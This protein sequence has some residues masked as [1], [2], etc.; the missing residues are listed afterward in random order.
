[1][2]AVTRFQF[3]V[4]ERILLHL[5]DY[6]KYADQYEVP[7]SVAQKGIGDAV[8]IVWNNVPR[9]MKK[10]M[11]KGAVVERLAH[12]KG[13][14]RKK[15][16]YFLTTVGFSQAKKLKDTIEQSKM[17]FK[18]ASGQTKTIALGEI[19]AL[20]NSKPPI[21]DIIRHLDATGVFDSTVAMKKG[22]PKGDELVDFS[23]KAP[24]MRYFFGRK[25]ELEEIKDL[26]DSHK[27]VIVH[28]IAGIGKTT[29]ALKIL[30]E[31]KQSMNTFWYRFHEWDTLRNLLTQLS[32]FLQACGRKAL[33]AYLDGTKTMDIN[34]AV[35]AFQKDIEDLMV[36][37][38]FDD[39]QKAVDEASQFFAAVTEVMEAIK[40]AKILIM[41][42]R[43]PG[44]YDRRAV[45][46]KEV[47]AEMKL[48]GLDK[49]SSRELLKM[50]NIVD[51]DI[52]DEIYRL[53][54]GHPLSL[55]L[56]DSVDEMGMQN[57]IMKFV[58]EEVFSK[59]APEEKK[60]L[61]IASVYRYPVASKAFFIDEEVSYEALD[62]LIDRALVQEVSFERYD[63]HDLIRE[64]FYTRLTPQQ[65]S[66]YHLC[67]AKYYEGETDLPAAIEAMYHYLR[68]GER[69]KVVKIGVEKGERMI[70]EGHLEELDS[71][72]AELD[73]E[74]FEDAQWCEVSILRGDILMAW[75]KLNKALSHY[76]IAHECATTSGSQEGLAKSYDRLGYLY[77]EKNLWESAIEFYNKY[78]EM[79]LRLNNKQGL[80]KA[81]SNF[82][83][84]Y[85]RK[86]EWDKAIEFYKKSLELCSREGPKEILAKT[87]NNLG[88]IFWEKGDYVNSLGEY[89]AALE[90]LEEMDDSESLRKVHF[91]LGEVY[92]NLGDL[93]NA[94]ESYLCCLKLAESYKLADAEEF[95]M[96][97]SHLGDLYRTKG[98]S[99]KADECYRKSAE[100]FKG[101]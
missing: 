31:Y 18:D 24:K 38:V 2:D 10:L 70:A 94:I 80:A 65:K 87:H 32:E 16:V 25:Q 58:H 57:N 99:A 36:L 83:S 85:Y 92:H 27:I 49:E 30:S 60:L 5:M 77:R 29:L 50:R 82:G 44:F 47:I 12:V 98:E 45:A 15:K 74:D 23:I 34:G 68:A 89:K 22:A 35:E 63:V 1:M 14:A 33:K 67:A 66:N 28:G 6:M 100:Y 101:V 26:I 43:L 71:L 75:G 40:A 55:E 37:M 84:I 76:E 52:I 86:A 19:Y 17:N 48:K 97:Y 79:M 21:L 91:N 90:V 72:L 81:Y 96:I 69:E 46:V 73:R 13:D 59:L 7:E 39:Y 41:T 62:K 78:L 3:T 42:R 51:D 56:L 61:R 95:A 4:H 88:I 9:A 11:S 8:G 53:T 20:I 64:F 93:D 54:E